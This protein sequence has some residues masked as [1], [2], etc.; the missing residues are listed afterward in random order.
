MQMVRACVVV[1]SWISYHTYV[2]IRWCILLRRIMYVML[3]SI[4][5]VGSYIAPDSLGCLITT[6]TAPAS[7]LNFANIYDG[8]HTDWHHLWDRF[9]FQDIWRRSLRQVITRENRRYTHDFAR[10]TGG[11]QILS[12]G[13]SSARWKPVLN[14]EFYVWSSL[15]C[16]C[17]RT[18][19]G[20]AHAGIW[21]LHP[22][23]R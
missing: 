8:F 1:S 10:D 6:P 15:C 4:I 19:S 16:L 14:G 18:F 5:S 13:E 20:F 17:I 23:S 11:S 2:R 21:R 12:R 22:Y 7:P 3:G 9:K